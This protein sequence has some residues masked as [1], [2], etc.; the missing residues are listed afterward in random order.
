LYSPEAVTERKH[1]NPYVVLASLNKNK[2]FP[3]F[4]VSILKSATA[5]GDNSYV[6]GM[7][8]RCNLISPANNRKSQK[9]KIMPFLQRITPFLVLE[10]LSIHCGL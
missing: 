7:R 9:K 4:C 6:L 10:Y 3:V 8:D 1:H 2:Q 5:V